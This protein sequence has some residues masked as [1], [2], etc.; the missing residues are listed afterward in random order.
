MQS[1]NND[2]TSTK[3]AE[4][5]FDLGAVVFR[6]RLPFK[7][8]SGI[9]SPV[10]VDN[11][12]IISSPKYRKIIVN[13]L[14]N[15]IKRIGL[16]DVIAGTATAGIPHAAWISQRLDLP[17][18][19]VRAKPKDH[20]RGNQVEG[21]LKRGQKVIVIEDMVSTAGS[22]A[23]VIEAIRKLGGKVTDEVAIYTH[24]LKE[25]DQNFHKLKVKF[26]PL[27]SLKEVAHIALQKGFLK[28]EQV[29]MILE[30]ANDPDNWGKK[31]GFK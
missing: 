28:E 19:F 11:R 20:G 10:Y 21:V 4:I 31:M 25:A 7:F 8:D 29:Q 17:M 14:V 30:W 1:T 3:V 15:E 24:T 9:L 13:H 18:I 27:T 22:S 26:H 2:K 5:L 23:R 12:L 16:P 6:P